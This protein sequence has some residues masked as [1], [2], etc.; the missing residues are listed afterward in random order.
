VRL[1]DSGGSHRPSLAETSLLGNYF[2]AIV[3]LI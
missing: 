2:Y 1:G 3:P